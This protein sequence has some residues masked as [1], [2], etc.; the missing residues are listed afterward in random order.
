MQ[1]N[2]CYVGIKNKRLSVIYIITLVV[3]G[4]IIEHFYQFFVLQSNFSNIFLVCFCQLVVH[5]LQN[6]KH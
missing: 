6:T 2:K 1:Q 5:F 4:E 3:I